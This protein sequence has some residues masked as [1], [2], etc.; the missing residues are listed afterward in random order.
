M[1]GR[2][3]HSKWE[4]CIKHL[5]DIVRGTLRIQDIQRRAIVGGGNANL[6]PHFTPLAVFPNKQFLM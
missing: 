4:K 1:D 3:V 6:Y 5:D 2:K